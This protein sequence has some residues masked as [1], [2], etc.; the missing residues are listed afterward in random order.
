MVNLSFANNQNASSF[1]QH[2]SDEINRLSPVC[3]NSDLISEAMKEIFRKSIEETPLQYYDNESKSWKETQTV[4][5]VECYLANLINYDINKGGLKIINNANSESRDITVDDFDA[6]AFKYIPSRI[7]LRDKE[8]TEDHRTEIVSMIMPSKEIIASTNIGEIGFG[9]ADIIT[10][11]ANENFCING[12]NEHVPGEKMRLW[13]AINGLIDTA[14]NRQWDPGDVIHYA[15][16]LIRNL[17]GDEIFKNSSILA[18]DR[19][20]SD[21]NTDGHYSKLSLTVSIDNDISMKKY[22][23][24]IYFEFNGFKPIDSFV[25][26]ISDLIKTSISIII[27][28]KSIAYTVE[29]INNDKKELA[30]LLTNILSDQEYKEFIR[31]NISSNYEDS[32]SVSIKD[33]YLG[34]D[35]KSFVDNME[36]IEMKITV[37]YPGTISC[38][39]NADLQMDFICKIYP[40]Q[41]SKTDSDNDQCLV[42]ISSDWY[43]TVDNDT[44]NMLPG[45]VIIDNTM[46]TDI[47]NQPEDNSFE[48]QKEEENK[49]MN[50]SNETIDNMVENNKT[51]DEIVNTESCNSYP[52]MLS[53]GVCYNFIFGQ[54]SSC[55]GN[56]QPKIPMLFKF[57]DMSDVCICFTSMKFNRPENMY[58]DFINVT[59]HINVNNFRAIDMLNKQSDSF[60]GIVPIGTKNVTAIISDIVSQILWKYNIIGSIDG[61]KFVPV[62]FNRDSAAIHIKIRST[63]NFGFENY[64][65]M[66]SKLIENIKNLIIYIV[67]NIVLADFSTIMTLT[68]LHD[69][70]ADE[71]YY[72]L[73]NNQLKN[74]H[75]IENEYRDLFI[76]NFYDITMDECESIIK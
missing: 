28:Q 66:N 62:P 38:K 27:A 4:S 20:S 8:Y 45:A 63:N 70:N 1:L 69:T 33:C 23:D 73:Y 11:V 44:S 64:V 12:Y 71:L 46:D 6:I 15:R 49:N 75:G 58:G 35:D 9:I 7:H 21:S 30:E 18:S 50:L 5:A 10:S 72:L 42:A 56:N 24:P 37:S 60:N 22:G 74:D 31:Y 52:F 76:E 61:I 57:P 41:I 51:S 67:K 2:V 17:L 14:V 25:R 16:P 65:R 43:Y 55:C 53:N 32:P 47:D 36:Y 40:N 3:W 54:R 19:K 59:S 26:I 48:S 34:K 13:S 68:R 39:T 29:Q